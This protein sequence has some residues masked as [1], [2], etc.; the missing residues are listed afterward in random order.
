MTRPLNSPAWA[1]DANYTSGDES[2]NPTRVQPLTAKRAQGF[3]PREKPGAQHFNYALGVHGDYLQHLRNIDWKNYRI[4][5]IA[6]IIGGGYALYSL[7]YDSA[8][9]PRTYVAAQRQ[10]AGV[11]EV[12]YSNNLTN[13][14]SALC[15]VGFA[16]PGSNPKGLIYSDVASLFILAGGSASTDGIATSP[17]GI[18]WTG[19]TDPGAATNRIAFAESASTIVL[20]RSAGGFLS[21]TNGTTWT[22][23]THP[24]ADKSVVDLAYSPTL[25]L[26]CAVNS[27]GHKITSPDG[28]TWT[29]R[30]NSTVMTGGGAI[31]WSTVYSKFFHFAA[32]ELE[33]SADGINWTKSATAVAN[34]GT[35]RRMLEWDGMILL[36]GDRIFAT[37]D[38][39]VSWEGVEAEMFVLGGMKGPDGIILCGSILPGTL[40]DA[41]IGVGMKV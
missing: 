13:W 27:A 37:V 22:E 29:D 41:A 18:T 26:F 11:A 19:R 9:I 8:D 4:R 38:G 24:A 2:G 33:Y 3:L 36:I 35:V 15:P 25:G 28:I 21:S 12:L 1:T 20:A 7:A 34:S 10:D 32:F 40:Q 30:G 17:D 31:E 39:G 16:L 5:N 6:D 23:R 14:S